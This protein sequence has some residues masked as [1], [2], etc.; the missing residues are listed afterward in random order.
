MPLR[1]I[2]WDVGGTLVRDRVPLVEHLRSRLAR[3]R[4]PT[5]VSEELL[6]SSFDTFMRD[7]SNRRTEADEHRGCVTWARELAASLSLPPDRADELALHLG[8]YEDSKEVVSGIPE[9]LAELRARGMRQVVVSNWPPSLPRF[10]AYHGLTAHFDA[11]VF[12]AQDGIPKPDPR[13][14]HRALR[15]AGVAP[16]DAL[17]I[18]DNPAWDLHPPRALGLRAIHF[19]PRLTHP[20]CDARDVPELRRA[21]SAHL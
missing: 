17:M 14:Y 20:D 16:A 13:I 21:L 19:D 8:V 6:V 18:G 7:E 1:A 9:L 10:L 5:D 2:L 3:A 12:S 15:A 4:W 11:V